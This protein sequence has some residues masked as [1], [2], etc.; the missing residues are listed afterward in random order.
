MRLGNR[1]RVFSP[2]W[3]LRCGR[4]EKAMV[5]RVFR[6]RERFVFFLVFKIRAL[7]MSKCCWKGGRSKE[8][9]KTHYR[10]FLAG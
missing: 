10:V 5:V 9:L 8:K 1:V 3:T 6:T 2:F 4:R 7:S